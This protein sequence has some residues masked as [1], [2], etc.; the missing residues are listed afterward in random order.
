[1]FIPALLGAATVKKKDENRTSRLR[2]FSNWYGAAAGG[3]AG[4][5]LGALAG[6]GLGALYGSSSDAE[7]IGTIAGALIGLAPGMFSGFGV[8]RRLLEAHN[9]SRENEL[10]REEAEA[11]DEATTEKS[12]SLDLFSGDLAGGIGGLVGAVHP[13]MSALGGITRGAGIGAGALAGGTIAGTLGAGLGAGIAS[14]AGND[15]KAG[16]GLGALLSSLPGAIYGGIKG[17]KKAKNMLREH[18]MLPD[19]HP[20][21]YKGERKDKDKKKKDS[22]KKAS[23]NAEGL[24][25]VASL[26]DM[27]A[28]TIGALSDEALLREVEKDDKAKVIL[29]AVKSAPSAARTVGGT[30]ATALVGGLGGYGASALAKVLFPQLNAVKELDRVGA[31]LGAVLGGISGFAGSKKNQASEA[32]D[33]LLKLNAVKNG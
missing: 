31:G 11:D 23:A 28:A 22:E 33:A 7:D 21:K 13:G 4:S 10:N 1:M 6:K 20:A 19:D 17:Y 25:K 29:S 15:I 26:L 30:A 2:E 14:L 8:A 5:T 18:A 24:K 16:A 3:L 27:D 12:A 32:R 9:R